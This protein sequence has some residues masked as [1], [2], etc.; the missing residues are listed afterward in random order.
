MQG[1]RVHLHASACYPLPYASRARS[2]SLAAGPHLVDL[3]A[4]MGPRFAVVVEVLP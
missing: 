3:T 4:D 1:I 2:V